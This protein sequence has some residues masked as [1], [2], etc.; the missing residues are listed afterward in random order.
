MVTA[1]KPAKDTLRVRP[2]TKLTGQQF[3]GD[4]TP[5]KTSQP[6][7]ALRF[8]PDVPIPLPD[9]TILRGDLYRPDA[10]GTFPLLLAWSGYT[11]ELQNTGLPLPINEIGQVSYIV[12]RGYCHLTVNARGTGK[13]EG[14]HAVHFCPGEQKDVADTIEWTATQ[15]WCNGQVGMVGM[16]Y[17]AAIQYLAAA[18][19]PPHLKAIFPYLGF[20]DLYR[21]F[22]YHGGAFHSGFF[23][24]YY[25]FVGSTQKISVP[26][27]VRHLASYLLNRNW[28]QQRITGF[29][30]KNEEKMP[31]QMHPEESWMRDFARLA[32]DEPHDGSF[33]WEKSAWPLLDRIQVP[34]CIGTNWA[35]PGIHMQGAFQAWHGIHA[36][37][38]LFIGP[39]D[40][41]WPWACYQDELLAW[42]DYYLKGID[43]G[44]NE[45]PA[46]RYWL[47]GA[48][49]W[50]SASDWP[51][52]GAIT[53]RLYLAGRSE[54][55]LDA[56]ILQVDVPAEPT[57]LSFVAIPRG[58]LYP[59]EL[60]KYEAQV[61]IYLTEPWKEETE[62]VGPVQLHLTLSSS[63]L[64]THVIARLSDVS[65]QGKVRLL[66]F[67]WL[68][69][70]HRRVDQ[71]RSRPDEIIHEHS[72]PEALTPHVPVSLVFSL[73]PTAN[74]FK[75]GHRLRLEIASR[76]DLLK[77]T[78]FDG[79]IYFPY[80]APPYPARNTVF[81]GGIA[82]SYLEIALCRRS[83]TPS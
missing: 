15:P 12:S 26:P 2:R 44:V 41:R 58:M 71:E 47:Q 55:N 62:M 57:A 52:P 11:K 33:Y 32:F 79:F 20:T 27:R 16:S 45:Q 53:Q 3:A 54:K 46:V 1:K 38:K 14:K 83:G 21:H 36:P 19:Q 37:K 75:R 18:Q 9:G 29:F 82:A 60:E 59:K 31:Q 49:C 10:G 66:S 74:L 81:H 78:V 50:R 13:S 51:I 69:A 23:A 73:T 65:P 8:E 64:D 35:N 5:K 7:Y 17:F 40:P 25:T 56:H 72:M 24:P 28:I 4:W 77:A 67:G 42:Y 34:V 22:A 48:N 68:Q 30:F 63:A 80:E 43:T 39:P 6:V 70:S 61:L 76:P